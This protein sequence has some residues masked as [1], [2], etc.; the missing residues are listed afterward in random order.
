MRAQSGTFPDFGLTEDQRREAV[1]G[2]YYEWPGMDGARGEIWATPPL[3]LFR[4]ATRSTCTSAP[5]RPPSASTS[6]ATAASRRT[7]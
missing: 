1:L 4:R 3:R 2:H 6:S 5:P 7:C